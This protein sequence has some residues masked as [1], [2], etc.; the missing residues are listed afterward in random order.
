MT[1]SVI[2]LAI[3]LNHCTHSLSGFLD[4]RPFVYRDMQS[5]RQ[6]LLQHGDPQVPFQQKRHREIAYN[7]WPMFQLDL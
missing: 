6:M 5:T 3:K 1:K 7:G 4:T 2:V